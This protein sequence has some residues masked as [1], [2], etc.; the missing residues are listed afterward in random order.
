MPGP[1]EIGHCPGEHIGSGWHVA[2]TR[3]GG[4]F[5]SPVV[6]DDLSQLLCAPD[7]GTADAVFLTSFQPFEPRFL[8]RLPRDA[9]IT[10]C[11][12]CETA[13]DRPPRVFYGMELQDVQRVEANERSVYRAKSFFCT[14]CMPADQ[15]QHCDTRQFVRRCRCDQT[16]R[17]QVLWLL[18]KLTGRDIMHSKLMLLR[19]RGFLRM[20]VSSFNWSELQWHESGD[21]FWWA[22]LPFSQGVT[23]D[24]KV[25]GALDGHL[26][27]PCG[28]GS[29]AAVTG[30]LRF[31]HF[32]AEPLLTSA[33]RHI[34][35][36]RV[37]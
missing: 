19:F 24:D 29:M 32:A 1:E 30:S 10:V 11:V 16:F 23:I 6:H 7:G 33:S 36:E 27:E 20:F 3:H 34:H 21:S 4:K 5:E 13:G 37:L 26:A 25:H 14:R 12:H 35:P 8:G 22:D 15:P 17:R 9:D 31:Q 28:T 2:Y 18:P